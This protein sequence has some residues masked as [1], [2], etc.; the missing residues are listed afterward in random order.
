MYWLEFIIS[1][2]IIVIAGTRL[3]VCA[4]KVSDELNLAKAWIG[5]VLLGVA[6]S[7]PEAI[8]SLVAIITL[9]ANDLAVGNLLGSNN[10]NPILIV[11]MD[12]LYRKGSVTDAVRPDRSHTVS[13]NFAIALSFLVIFDMLFNGAYPAAHWGRFSLGGLL[14]AVCYVIG[15]RQ[16]ARL[17]AGQAMVTGDKPL[18]RAPARQR[19]WIELLLSIVFVVIGAMWLTESADMIAAKTGL[20]RTFVGSIFL[21]VVTSLP[22]MVVSLS[23]MRMGALDLAIGNIFGSNM[24]NMFI[25]FVCSLFNPSR[26]LLMTVAPKHMFTAALSILLV[27][28]AIRGIMNKNKKKFLAMGW[29]SI[30]MIILFIAG[31]AFLYSV[32]GL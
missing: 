25:L 27:H 8:T 2:V 26:P 32:R 7:L 18:T 1:A 20:G 23:A 24:A 29:D 13:A 22:E 11:I 5:I 10:F 4:D 9:K 19:L 16:L 28:T 30:A 21:A 14:I 17:G 3:T 15:M 6:T 31:T 12:I